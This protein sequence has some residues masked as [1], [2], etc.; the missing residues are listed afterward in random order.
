MLNTNHLVYQEQTGPLMQISEALFTR[1]HLRLADGRIILKTD[2]QD[3]SGGFG[4][5]SRRHLVQ[6]L[7][8]PALRGTSTALH[9]LLYAGS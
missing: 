7:V 1:L 2:L 4:V 3:L 6:Q 9:K 8:H 5:V